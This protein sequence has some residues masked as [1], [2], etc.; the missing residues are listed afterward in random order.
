M[1][2][3][4]ALIKALSLAFGPT[5]CEGAVAELIK[6]E[7]KDLPVSLA[8][9]RMGNLVAHLQG[10]SGAPRVLLS[11]HMDEVGFLTADT[12]EDGT[13]KVE[14]DEVTDENGKDDGSSVVSPSLPPVFGE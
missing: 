4:I 1:R 5:G 13:P 3:G 14:E 8:Y 7:I 9:D 6:E 2:E 11:A 12:N 10:P